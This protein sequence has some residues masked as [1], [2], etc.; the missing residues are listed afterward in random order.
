MAKGFFKRNRSAGESKQKAKKKVFLVFTTIGDVGGLIVSFI[1]VSF[2]ALSIYLNFGDPIINW[3]MLGITVA[4]IGFYLFKMVYLN[5]NTQNSGRV[6]RIVKISKK[7]TKLAIR[8][9]N[10][11]FVT[12]T[13]VN[14]HIYDGENAFAMIGVM[15]VAL[16][17]IITV[18]WD[19]GNLVIRRK[20]QQFTQSWT[21]LGH[22]E[23]AER[24][25]LLLTGFIKSIN[26]AAIIDDYFDVALNIQ[27]M[28]GAKLN[29]RVRLADARRAE[30][31]NE[32]VSHDE[33]SRKEEVNV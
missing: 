7:Y 30:P 1:Y 10:A 31:N 12:L 3:I 20:M 19:I 9:I 22:E 17:F 26:D 27:R 18:L 13:L 29:D 14:T 11:V 5:K 15:V 21:K 28:I 4:Y 32:T 33:E 23:K 24:I 25:E 6:K 16:T 8:I 2:V